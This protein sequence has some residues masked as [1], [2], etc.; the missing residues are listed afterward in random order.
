[1]VRNA[2][3]RGGVSVCT[4][5]RR[6]LPHP[7]HRIRPVTRWYSAQTIAIFFRPIDASVFHFF[8]PANQERGP[9]PGGSARAP[10]A[11]PPLAPKPGHS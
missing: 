5:A 4:I 8:D 1:M 9:R 2:I 11:V 10:A 3:L 7:R 6:F